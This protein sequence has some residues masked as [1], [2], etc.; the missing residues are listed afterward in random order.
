MAHA[1]RLWVQTPALYTW[2]DVSDAS[3]YIQ[4]N[5]ENTGSG[6]M[7]TKKNIEKKLYFFIMIPKKT[8]KLVCNKIPADKEH[9]GL[10]LF[11]QC[12]LG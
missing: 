11:K 7:P 9:L 5:N 8:I 1:H 12:L 4:E 6:M 10:F 3:Y 2:M